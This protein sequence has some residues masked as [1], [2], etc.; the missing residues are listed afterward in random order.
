MKHIIKN[1]NV[2]KNGK[3]SKQDFVFFSED[4]SLLGIPVST[5]SFE[6][7]IFF[8]GFVD[9][10][11]HLR[12]PGF[13]YKETIATGTTAAAKMGYTDVFS[14]PNLSPVPDCA[15][16]LKVELDLIE[17]TQKSAS[18]PMARLQKRRGDVA[19]RLLRAKRV[20]GRIFR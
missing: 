2:F 18:I 11:V 19:C 13:F 15:G 1:A 14:M 8:P 20:C 7:Y 16:N 12:E 9:A 3:I 17:K 10:H 4:F 5:F 6:K